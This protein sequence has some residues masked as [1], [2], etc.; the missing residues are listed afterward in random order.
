MPTSHQLL[1]PDDRIPELL[2]LPEVAR[3]LPPNRGSKPVHP[4]TLTRWIRRGVLSSDGKRIRLKAMRLPGG[5]RTTP[6]WVNRFLERITS[7]RIE[8]SGD[9]ASEIRSPS[10]RERAS[11]RARQEL[12]ASGF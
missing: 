12:K 8:A 10:E 7:D 11:T 1:I 6:E 4:A 2:S 3:K 5:W 9:D